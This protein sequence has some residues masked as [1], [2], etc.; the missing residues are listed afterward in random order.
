VCGED[1]VTSSALARLSG[2]PEAGHAIARGE[3]WVLS[4]SGDVLIAADR[5]S[6]QMH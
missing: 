6:A 4:F 3:G 1:G 2:R 5:F